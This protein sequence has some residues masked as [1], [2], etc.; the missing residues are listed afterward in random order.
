M[1]DIQACRR[2]LLQTRMCVVNIIE[3][4]SVENP[5]VDEDGAVTHMISLVRL[6]DTLLTRTGKKQS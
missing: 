6:I 3:A 5:L 2:L 1:T 4:R